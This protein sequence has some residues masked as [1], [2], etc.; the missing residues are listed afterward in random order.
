M[1]FGGDR[2]QIEP[3]VRQLADQMGLRDWE[4]VLKDDVPDSETA[5]ASIWCWYAQRHAELRV[6]KNWAEFT[7]ELFRKTMVHEVLHCHTRMLFEVIENIQTLLGDPVYQVTSRHHRDAE[8]VMV[9]DI[10]VAWARLLPLPIRDEATA[11]EA[12]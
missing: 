3:Y 10:A 2:S 11:E 8:E 9:D 7:P 12:A 1:I 4:I 5:H 6:A